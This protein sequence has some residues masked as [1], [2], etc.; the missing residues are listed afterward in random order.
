MESREWLDSLDT[1]LELDSPDR[2][3]FVTE[4]AA[5]VTRPD[6]MPLS[7]PTSQSEARPADLIAWTGGRASRAL[8]VVPGVNA[9]RAHRWARFA[10]W[11][12]A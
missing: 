3:T 8:L 7:N 4:M 9:D 6:I 11:L 2:A 1:V 10:A 5:H 12:Q